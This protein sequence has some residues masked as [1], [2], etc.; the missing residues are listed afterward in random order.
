[1]HTS[2]TGFRVALALLCSAPSLVAQDG[3]AVSLLPEP[4]ALVEGGRLDSLF[5]ADRVE[6]PQDS[7][8]VPPGIPLP[9][10]VT[11]SS[12]Q[13]RT[14]FAESLYYLL[15]NGYDPL[16][17]PRPLLVAY[18]GYGMSAETPHLQSTLDEQAWAQGWI[19]MAPTGLDK[20]VFGT[21]TSQ[22]NTEAAI[23]WML[24]NFQVDPDRICMVGF[25]MGAGITASFAARHRDPDGIMLAAVGL[26]SGTTDWTMEYNRGT[27]AAKLVLEHPL[28]FGGSSVAEPFRY[29]QASA[30]YFDPATYPWSPGPS[31]GVLIA[32]LSM[33]TNLHGMPTYITCDA[34]DTIPYVPALADELDALLGSLG[35][36]TQK[37]VVT[38]T[39]PAT[40]S[41][42][43]LDE[44]DL[45]AFFAG[46]VANR[47][48]TSFLAQLDL[49]G[50]VAW[51]G[52]EQAAAGAFSYVDGWSDAGA[53]ILVMQSIAN[54]AEVGVDSGL[55]GVPTGPRISAASADALGTRLAV[56]GFAQPPSYLLE[57]PGGGYL[58]GVDSAPVAGELRIDVAPL[59]VLAF[60]VVHD[61]DWSGL[62]TTTPNPAAPGG[63]IQL[64]V[65]GSPGDDTAW[66]IV[67]AA[68]QLLAVKGFT[69]AAV[70]VPPA[71]VFPLPLNG[72]GL[73]AAAGVLPNDPLL[74][75]L[76]LPTQAVLAVGFSTPVA[77]TN[78]WGL[79]IE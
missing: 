9:T 24:A 54:A 14:G 5:E 48:P 47:V 30:L 32:A 29:Q 77:V 44:L 6:V 19:Y 33:A 73:G 72:S 49:G 21:P 52:L 45:L 23:E 79:R 67:A 8:D 10:E 75:G 34:G 59:D 64:N 65:A 40:H 57:A 66:V 15:P 27:A 76:R 41:W 51:V 17:P 43:V 50:R 39:T 12:A 74:V 36:T 2:W 71:I 26:V 1:M 58:P 22:E 68:E 4:P 20:Q 38:G 35:G 11:L 60:D 55:A 46:K 37:V 61:P 3:D 63:P 28:N 13:T 18:H 31:V 69:I 42:A 25:S 53:G 56:G 16:G 78:L 7:T 70:P 62:L